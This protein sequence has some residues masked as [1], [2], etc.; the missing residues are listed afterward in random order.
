LNLFFAPSRNLAARRL[1][2]GG[3]RIYDPR[4]RLVL[5]AADTL[6][7]GASRLTGLRPGRDLPDVRKVESVL[8]LRLDRLGDLLTTLPAIELVRKALPRARIDLAVGSWNEPVAR[9]LPF[10]DRVRV[11][12]APWSAW[13]KNAR[14]RD[15]RAALGGEPFDL[16]L[17]FQG[18]VRVILLMALSGAK[19]RAGYGDTGGGYLLTHQA[20]WDEKTSWYE[21]NVA[22]VRALFPEVGPSGPVRPYNFVTEADRSEAA[23]L[24]DSRKRPLVGIHPS[25]GRAL[26]EWEPEKYAA[27]ADRLS[28]IATVVLTG[29]EADR[30]LASRILEKT[31]SRPETLIGLSLPTFAAVIERFDAFVTGDTGPMHLSHAVGTKN[32]AIFGPSDPVRY[33]PDESLGLRRVVRSAVYCSPCNMI[34]RPPPEC[35]RV[36][37]P[38]CLSTI[39][40]DPVLRAV[41]E[42]LGAT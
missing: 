17:D 28:E 16:A 33:G 39:T 21:Q 29:A 42:T 11:V 7:R 36:P 5:K 13:G 38:E 6:L 8:A 14:I 24:V 41:R 9:R 26:K 10:V 19:L 30:P 23:R 40:L 2:R 3:P 27:L 12:D 20:R 34:R 35:A 25:A 32:V 31:A 18:D 37:T 1:A 15:A 4:E 22:L